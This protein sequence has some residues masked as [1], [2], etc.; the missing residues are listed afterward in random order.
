MGLYA[1]D[2][3]GQDSAEQ[4]S[5]S[6]TNVKAFHDQYE[7]QREPVYFA[8]PG[9]IFGMNWDLF[10]TVGWFLGGAFAPE[11]DFIVREAYSSLCKAWR[12]G[13]SDIDIVGYSRGAAAAL[14]FAWVV[15]QDGIKEPGSGET[16]A[17]NPKIR[18]LG[19]WDT[20]FFIMGNRALPDLERL[21]VILLRFRFLQNLYSSKFEKETGSSDLRIPPIVEQTFHALAL[22]ER[23]C[24]FRPAR[25]AGESAKVREV[26]FAGKH[27]DIGGQEGKEQLSELSLNWMVEKAQAC[28]VP[29]SSTAAPKGG[30]D[31]TDLEGH[32]EWDKKLKRDIRRDDLMH[33][34]VPD[35]ARDAADAI[36][37]LSV[38]PPHEESQ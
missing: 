37:G 22:H 16:L 19:L 27:T 3:T 21:K 4:D 18:F 15:A 33:P 8:G 23:R 12:E 9:T 28:G 1:F 11:T 26:W 31:D 32:L 29:V 14:A 5:A 34:S 13:D 20:V 30:V 36:S 17:S 10:G 6:W 38:E 25:L 2:G 7:G 24:A 35:F